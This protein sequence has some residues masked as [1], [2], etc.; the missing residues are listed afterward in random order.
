MAKN[1]IVS[2]AALL[3]DFSDSMWTTPNVLARVNERR[4]LIHTADGKTHNHAMA[5]L[6]LFSA[7]TREDA[8]V[9]PVVRIEQIRPSRFVGDAS[10]LRMTKGN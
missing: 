10:E 2:F 6:A 1:D 4:Y 3:D 9:S 5:G 7:L 8:S